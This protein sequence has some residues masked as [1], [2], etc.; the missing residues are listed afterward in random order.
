MLANRGTSAMFR[1]ATLTAV[2]VLRA[3]RGDPAARA[4][5]DE[6][7]QLARQSGEPERLVPV[8]AARAELAWLS[9]DRSSALAEASVVLDEVA[10]AGRAWYVAEL[11]LWAWRGGGRPSAAGCAAPVAL[12]LEGDWRA[13]SEAWERLGSRYHAALSRYE[14]SDPAALLE[15]LEA[16]DQLGARPAAARVRRRL[17]ELGV[18]SVP[19]GPRSAR[20]AHPFDLTAREQ[21]VLATLA[22]GLTNDEIGAR[23]FVSSKTVDHHVSAILG[24]LGVRSRGA[25]VAE[26]HRTG[27]V[28]QTGKAQFAK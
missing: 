25:A 9:G 3:R 7:W 18:R 2:G 8:A 12:Q 10:P 15:A 21:E 4:A 28:A 24:K 17:S 27:L 6:A 1:L 19:R 23:L 26:A 14:S 13:A 11:S 22:L 20:R 5:L 16:L